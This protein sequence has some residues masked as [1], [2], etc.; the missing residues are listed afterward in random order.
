MR[1]ALTLIALPGAALAH[2][3][4]VTEVAGHN[5]WLGAAALGLAIAVAV[6]AA[7]KSRKKDEEPEIAA[8]DE[9]D[10]EEETV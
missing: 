3:G 6:W 9:A 1:L 8:E 5:H 10:T 4:H 2:P 7:L